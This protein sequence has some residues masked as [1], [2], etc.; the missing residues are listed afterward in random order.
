MTTLTPRLSS[1]KPRKRAVI[2]GCIGSDTL[3][4]DDQRLYEWHGDCPP[5]NFVL[6]KTIFRDR[7]PGDIAANGWTVLRQAVT[8]LATGCGLE[9]VAAPLD[10]LKLDTVLERSCR[11]GVFG[12][13]IVTAAA[14][15]KCRRTPYIPSRYFEYINGRRDWKNKS[16]WSSYRHFN[17]KFD[18]GY[19]FYTDR[20]RLLCSVSYALHFGIH[21]YHSLLA[22]IHIDNV[23][24][25]APWRLR[26]TETLCDLPGKIDWLNQHCHEFI[27]RLGADWLR[28]SGDVD[29][30]YD[31][32]SHRIRPYDFP[33]YGLRMLRQER[34]LAQ[35]RTR[36]DMLLII[37]RHFDLDSERY[38]VPLLQLSHD[39]MKGY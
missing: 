7:T 25:V 29:M 15:L 1:A 11:V 24:I 30:V 10:W 14:P 35:C 34:S 13:E 39:F 33:E 18:I 32:I 5:R 6:H 26:I 36:L 8:E 22:L 19:S 20:H 12:D 2:N 9:T 31:D 17:A 23:T 37:L 28:E 21:H 16:Y 4:L 27:A 38:A 3:I